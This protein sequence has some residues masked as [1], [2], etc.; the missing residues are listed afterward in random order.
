MHSNIWIKIC[1]KC[2]TCRYTRSCRRPTFLYRMARVFE[3]ICPICWLANR[4]AGR[5]INKSV[6][7]E[8]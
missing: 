8:E 4:A 1:S 2:P 7:F 6:H 3:K 5:D